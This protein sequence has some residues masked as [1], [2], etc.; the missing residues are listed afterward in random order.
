MG[1]LLMREE[2]RHFIIHPIGTSISTNSH[3]SCSNHIDIHQCMN[4][5]SKEEEEG[6]VQEEIPWS[7]SRGANLGRLWLRTTRAYFRES[8]H[9][10]LGFSGGRRKLEQWHINSIFFRRRYTRC[11]FWHEMFLVITNFFVTLV[12]IYTVYYS[13]VSILIFFSLF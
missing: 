4:Q 5:Y 9:V 2:K 12:H 1:R 8:E 3:L 10:V 6:V 13:T 7:Q 11:F